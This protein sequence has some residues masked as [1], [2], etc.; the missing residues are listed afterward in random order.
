MLGQQSD[1]PTGVEFLVTLR[2]MYVWL[3]A[4][5]LTLQMPGIILRKRCYKIIK[6]RQ[7]FAALL[8]NLKEK[9]R[10]MMIK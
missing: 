3:P 7:V 5:C 9:Q 1:N 10:V 8:L 4:F 2:V 6:N